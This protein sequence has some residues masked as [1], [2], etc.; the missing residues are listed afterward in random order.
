MMFMRVGGGKCGLMLGVV[1]VNVI[2]D[3]VGEAV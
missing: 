3:D 2:A 1:L